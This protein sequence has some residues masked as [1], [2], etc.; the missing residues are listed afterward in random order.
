MTKRQKRRVVFIV[1]GI[2][3][4]FIG[5]A[6]ITSAL[7]DTIVFFYSPTEIAEKNVKPG[8]R[9][10]V[11]GLVA[12]G[13]VKRE[14]GSRIE[15]NVSDGKT[16]MK[17]TYVGLLPDLFREKQGVVAE[18]QLD[19]TGTFRAETILAKHDEKYVPREVAD[20]LKKQGYWQGDGKKPAQAPA[21]TQPQPGKPI[22]Q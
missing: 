15:F 9:I 17:V 16:S 14:A 19:E 18:G 8:Q 21:S 10:R 6:L 13:S 2:A 12:E 20:A 22:S 11:G 3:A 7:L 1:G 4:I 5:I